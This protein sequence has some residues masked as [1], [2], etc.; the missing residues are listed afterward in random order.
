MLLKPAVNPRT[1]CAQTQQPYL[2]HPL[3]PS[4]KPL[5]PRPQGKRIYTLNKPPKWLTIPIG[6]SH[7]VAVARRSFGVIY[8]EATRMPTM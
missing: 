6:F 8:F 1:A 7:R 2:C 5:H 3:P 4:V